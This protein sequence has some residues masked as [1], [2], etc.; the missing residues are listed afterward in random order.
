MDRATGVAVGVCIAIAIGW[1]PLAWV[2]RFRASG[3]LD[4]QH[5]TNRSPGTNDRPM[6]RLRD[7]SNRMLSL[8]QVPAI[9][10]VVAAVLI[11]VAVTR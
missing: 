6:E 3:W 7:L 9:A 11:V 8:W 10:A 4:W 2:T 5:R 1:W